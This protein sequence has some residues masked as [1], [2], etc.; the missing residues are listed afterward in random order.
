MKKNMLRCE[1]DT[2]FLHGSVVV[3]NENNE[4]AEALGIA[5]NRIAYVGSDRGIEP[6]VS[7]N[8]RVVDLAGRTLMPGLTD[9]HWHAMM[10]RSTPSQRPGSN[11]R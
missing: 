1:L 8:T 3:V 5:G 4:V 7:E 6:F 11:G 10:V 9:M 2:A